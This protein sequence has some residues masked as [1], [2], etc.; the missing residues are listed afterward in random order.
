MTKKLYRG[1]EVLL[2]FI[3]NDEQGVPY[4]FE[5]QY[6]RLS[7]YQPKTKTEILEEALELRD[8]VG[9]L[10]LEKEITAQMLGDY[11]YYIRVSNGDFSAILEVG[12]LEVL[13]APD[14]ED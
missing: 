5:G 2:K 10:R 11:E 14:F 8:N 9:S 12:E 6:V 7:I 1:D 3:F 4:D 13:F